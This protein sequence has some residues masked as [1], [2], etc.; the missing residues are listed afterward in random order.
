MA[1]L[2]ING[3]LYHSQY[4]FR[5]KRSTEHALIII[6]ILNRIQSNFDEGMLSC[7]VFINLKKA[8][9]SVDHFILFKKLRLKRYHQ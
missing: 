6:D 2:E 1:F 5:G 7:G 3:V 4:G 9:D 8:F